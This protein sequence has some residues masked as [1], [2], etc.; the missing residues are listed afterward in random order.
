M[1]LLF[2]HYAE[3]RNTIRLFLTSLRRPISP[4]KYIY[5][6]RNADWTKLKNLFREK[7]PIN[8]DMDI[9][10]AWES[11]KVVFWECVDE[12]IPKRL[13]KCK[14]RHPWITRKILKLIK[15]RNSL[16]KKWRNNPTCPLTHSNY[17]DIKERTR[18]AI[19]NAH[20]TYLWNL[21]Q[22][23]DGQQNLWK[24]IHKKSG[25]NKN[26]FPNGNT[27]HSPEETC[28]L[29]ADNFL[30]NFNLDTHAASNLLPRKNN[31]NHQKLDAI[32][33]SP[34]IV[35][36]ALNNLRVNSTAGIDKISPRI[37]RVCALELGV[38]LSALFNK[39]LSSC[40]LPNEWK[41]ALV[42]PI[43]KSG[44]KCDI[45]NYR[46][47][48]M[49]S[50]VCK[51]LEKIINQC[52]VTYLIDTN[53][54]SEFQHGFLPKRSCNTMLMYTINEWQKILDKSSGGHIHAISLDW[55]KAFDRIPHS[56]LLLKLNN[57]GIT[58]ML[59][60]WFN[61]YL[62]D[63]TQRVFV[64]GTQ[65]KECKVPSGV[66]QGSVLGPLLFNI[67]VSDLPN[68]VDSKLIMY[69]DDST[70]YR[71]ISSYDDEIKLQED[72]NNIMY[73]SSVNGMKLNASKCTSMDITL[74]NLRRFGR[75]SINDSLLTHA[76]HIK[77][78]GLNI[79]YNLSWNFH[80]EAVRNKSA[81]LIA[82]VSRNL[83]GCTRK[84]KQQSYLYLIRPV[85][86][87]GAPA[88]HP[89]T[90]EN[91]NKLQLLQNRASRFIYGKDCTHELDKK[92]L[93]H[94]LHLNLLDLV[95]FYKCRN[96]LIDCNVTSSVVEGRPFRGQEGVNR[97]IPPKA[98]TSLFQQGFVYRSTT[99]WNDLPSHIK[100][101][102]PGAF[103]SHLM[104]HLLSP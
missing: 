52:I 91:V 92:I 65:S 71:Q 38:S 20:E 33:T 24:Y 98:R 74:S 66:I 69:A 46:P 59:L 9:D 88:W 6:Y 77:L 45:N 42:I 13:S 103:K 79:S 87:Y 21:G 63:R 102:V 54:I 75:Y 43:H 2:K 99:L 90:N 17:I 80:N 27:N 97:L 101:A 67:F 94:S 85:M 36:N 34:L 16:F 1:F 86:T 8:F 55:E 15:S 47:I 44:S 30:S 25:A 68:C 93:C 64:N 62:S 32:V 49:L 19:K 3:N 104:S 100:L 11:W 22:G 76:D 39:S 4:K 10:T 40:S 50:S 81:K 89:T 96:N 78:L 73:W 58:G 57:A 48:S 35:E 41:S 83:K 12:C 14:V 7:L 84:V 82:F 95:Y 61:C 70:L 5:N 18:N 37:L 56:R 26:I 23:R 60:K 29:F 53:Q 51:V 28:N 31:D 72:L